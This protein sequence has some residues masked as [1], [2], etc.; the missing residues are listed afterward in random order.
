MVLRTAHNPPQDGGPS[1]C[2]HA[3]KTGG[4]GNMKPREAKANPLPQLLKAVCPKFPAGPGD[5]SSVLRRPAWLHRECGRLS[6]HSS[7]LEAGAVKAGPPDFCAPGTEGEPGLW[8]HMKDSPLR[9][10]WQRGTGICA[11]SSQ[12]ECG[13]CTHEHRARPRGHSQLWKPGLRR[14]Q[15]SW[16][17]SGDQLARYPGHGPS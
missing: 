10:A 17:G 16:R 8:R 9:C 12:Q 5:K 3:V 7:S 11:R 6:W 4:E 1:T 14:N 13:P 2:T 15:G